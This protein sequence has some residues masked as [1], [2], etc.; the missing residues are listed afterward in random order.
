MGFTGDL[1]GFGILA[2]LWGLGDLSLPVLEIPD[3]LELRPEPGR[4]RNS[5]G[6]PEEFQDE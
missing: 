2:G 3:V 1:W 6:I 5:K 4:M